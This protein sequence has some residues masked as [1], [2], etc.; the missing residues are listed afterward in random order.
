MS[1][2]CLLL[3]H[4][5]AITFAEFAYFSKKIAKRNFCYSYNLEVER[6]DYEA[7]AKNNLNISEL[8]NSLVIKNDILA[9]LKKNDLIT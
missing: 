7:M 8:K 1:I 6:F 2:L 9:S 5:I 3:F 4:T